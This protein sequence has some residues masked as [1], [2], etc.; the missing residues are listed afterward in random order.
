V[1]SGCCADTLDD[2]RLLQL[3]RRIFTYWD[4][5]ARLLSVA[6]D[7]I[8]ALMI[9][10]GHSYHGAFR[11]LHGWRDSSSDIHAL[12]QALRDALKQLGHSDVAEQVFRR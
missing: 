10:E 9:D 7:E 12:M 6:D 2:L 3:S 5:L 8:G 11:M 1:Y 4:E